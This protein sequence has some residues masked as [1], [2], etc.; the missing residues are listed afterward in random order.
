MDAA[1][2]REACKRNDLARVRSSYTPALGRAPDEK[3]TQSMHC[4]CWGGALKMAQW[5]HEQG[6]PLDVATNDGWRPMHWACYGGQLAV[7]RWLH[8]QGVPHKA[9]LDDGAQPMHV[10]C[11][12]GHLAMAK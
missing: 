9:A 7:A 10:A 6:V 1:A 11:Q 4:A 5:L 12:E 8:E 3:G 2:F